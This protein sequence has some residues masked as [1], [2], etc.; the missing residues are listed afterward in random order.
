[1]RSNWGV[2]YHRVGAIDSVPDP[3]TIVTPEIIFHGCYP[4]VY[5]EWIDDPA[6]IEYEFGFAQT[7]PNILYLFDECAYEPQ[8]TIT[9]NSFTAK[10][11]CLHLPIYFLVRAVYDD[12]AGGT[13]KSNWAITYYIMFDGCIL[14]N[15]PISVEES[16]WGAISQQQGHGFQ[17]GWPGGQK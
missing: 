17:G 8:N 7:R 1:M 12:G 5:H 10:H 14:C 11:D 6:A 16:T 13:I 2:G 15:E 4:A 9:S 3:L